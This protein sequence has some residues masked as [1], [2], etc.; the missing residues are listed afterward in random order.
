MTDPRD[1]GAPDREGRRAFLIGAG[2]VGA[3]LV[4]GLT[5]ARRGGLS[6]LGRGEGARDPSGRFAPNAFVRIAPDNTVTVVIGKAEMGQSVYTSLPQIVG[7]ELDFDPRR[8]RVEFAPVEAAY[9][10][11]FLPIQFTGGS[12][13]I[14]S[15]YEQFRQAG[16]TARA[17]LVAAAAREWG[18]DAASIRTENGTLIDGARKSTYGE[19]ATAAARLAPPKQ[20]ALKD[21]STFRY[22][23]RSI[24]RLD[25]PPKVDGRAV[26]SLDVKRPGMLIGVVAHPPV[27]GG[28]VRS[29]DDTEARA[30]PGVVDVLAVPNGI[31]VVAVHTWAALRGRDALRIEWDPAGD[32]AL[33]TARLRETYRA[34]LAESGA[35]AKNEGDAPAVLA[36]SGVR[37]LDVEY[38]LP[39]VAHACM[40]PL[41]CVAEVTADRCELW[42][43]SQFQ[44]EDRIAVAAALGLPRERVTLNTTFLGGAFGR[45]ANPKS[46]FVVEAAHLA[47]AAGRPVK[48]LWTREDDLR[49]GWYRPFGLSR[50]RAALGEDG[51]PVAWHHVIAAQPVLA[52]SAFAPLVLVDGRDPTITEGIDTMPWAMP[53]LRVEVHQMTGPVPVQWWRSV[54]H[55]HTGFVVNGV[56][57]ELAALGGRDPLA[58]RRALLAG[59]PRHLAVL[60]AAATRAGWNQPQQPGHHLGLALVES[61]GSIVAQV[62]EV[63]VRGRDVQVHRVTCAVDCGLAV[64]PGHVIAQMEGSVVWGLSSALQEEIT[65][66]NGRVVQGN[67]NDYPILR[68]PDVPFIDTVLVPSDGPMGGIGEPGVPPVAPALC[69]AIFAATGRR[70]RRLPVRL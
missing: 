48:L 34:K 31:G 44:S 46:D 45:R 50:V 55:S 18:T 33:T 13:S 29:V 1:T 39:Y 25:G 6:G 9:N 66:E 54:G 15:S 60:N 37:S 65:L 62:V 16:A 56:L 8:I 40:E 17:M 22:I 20:V 58:L 43:G 67:F 41:N 28:A 11:P 19:L 2:V 49:A 21:P 53:N 26:F 4:L 27:F 68:L 47:K 12:M 24:R 51:L 14:P 64:N 7:E 36:A 59:K 10:H 42:V 3:G 57:D 35:V 63:S 52:D 32:S 5:I 23:G 70:I 69:N 38:E 30:V 61:F